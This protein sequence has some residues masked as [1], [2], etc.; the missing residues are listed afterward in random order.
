[1]GADGA[2]AIG[3]EGTCGEAIEVGLAGVGGGLQPG[4]VAED[5]WLA[6]PNPDQGAEL[7]GG[8]EL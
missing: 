5:G 4:G 2:K 3:R 1:M 6:G 8:E 7:G